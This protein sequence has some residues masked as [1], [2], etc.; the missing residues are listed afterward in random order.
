MIIPSE[1]FVVIKSFLILFLIFKIAE[2]KLKIFGTVKDDQGIYQ[3]F[4]ENE[5]GNVQASAQLLVDTAG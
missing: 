3:C 4:A 2:N 1:Y 5:V